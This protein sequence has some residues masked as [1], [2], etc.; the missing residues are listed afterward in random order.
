MNDNIIVEWD[1]RYSVGIPLVDEQH[2]EL[3]RLTNSL[4]ESCLAGDEAARVS[5]KEAIQGTVEYVKFHFGAEERILTNVHYPDFA[6]HK[7]QHEEFVKQVLG[8]VKSFEEGKKFVPNVFVR[9]LRDWILTHIALSDKKYA[10]YIFELKK[11][12]ALV[13]G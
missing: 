2:K 5:F 9:F 8:E 7:K 3:I 6:L 11:K 12:G 13:K 1:D 4:Y 10:E